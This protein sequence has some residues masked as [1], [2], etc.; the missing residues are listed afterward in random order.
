MPVFARKCKGAQIAVDVIPHASQHAPT[1]HYALAGAR[2]AKD[3]KG[4]KG[5]KDAKGPKGATSAKRKSANGQQ[6]NYKR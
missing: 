1:Y 3:V 6:Y 4:A 5:A 2:R